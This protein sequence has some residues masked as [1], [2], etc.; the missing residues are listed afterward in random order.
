MLDQNCDIESS[1]LVELREQILIALVKHLRDTRKADADILEERTLRDILDTLVNQL[2]SSFYTSID[3]SSECN[4]AKTAYTSMKD[5]SSQVF[6][7]RV[8][9]VLQSNSLLIDEWLIT[10]LYMNPKP[11]VDWFID[12]GLAFTIFQDAIVI[13]TIIDA[14][15]N[16]TMADLLQLFRQSLD[17]SK[18]FI[19]YAVETKLVNHLTP[20]LE[21][22]ALPEVRNYLKRLVAYPMFRNQEISNLTDMDVLYKDLKLPE[23]LKSKE[24]RIEQEIQAKNK[25]ITYL[26]IAAVVL[27]VGCIYLSRRK[28]DFYLKSEYVDSYADDPIPQS[29]ARTDIPAFK[30]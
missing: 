8:T 23:S 22:T 5:S 16:P 7:E 20:G 15:Y 24:A 6:R 29:F 1:K 18:Q 21:A 26:S 28:N 4:G 14:S 2:E 30:G 3:P 13:R 9:S 10:N 25:T 12:E 27:G 17:L 11:N 19:G